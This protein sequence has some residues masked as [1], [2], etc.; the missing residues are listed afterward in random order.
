[1]AISLT[2]KNPKTDYVHDSILIRLSTDSA[3]GGTRP[4]SGQDDI[5]APGEPQFAVSS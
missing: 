3:L 1:M 2:R 4:D 5:Q